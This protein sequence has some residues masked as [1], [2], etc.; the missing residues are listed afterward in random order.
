MFA[1]NELNFQNFHS[2]TQGSIYFAACMSFYH[3]RFVFKNNIRKHDLFLY[4]KSS[5]APQKPYFQNF[6]SATQGSI[7]FAACMSFYHF[8]F[9]FKN[10]IRKH[11]LFLYKKSSIAPRKKLPN[12]PCISSQHKFLF[13]NFNI[14]SPFS[15][16]PL[17]VCAAGWRFI[18][19]STF[20]PIH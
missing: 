19:C 17:Q 10:N 18:A 14:F 2:A 6:H 13:M 8:R 4:K 1:S 3:F 9:V 11:D 7:Y 16:E 15:G 5:I 12:I 20:C